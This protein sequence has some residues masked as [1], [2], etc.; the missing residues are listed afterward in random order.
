MNRRLVAALIVP[1]LLGLIALQSPLPAAPGLTLRAQASSVPQIISWGGAGDNA[2]DF[3]FKPN[4]VLTVVLNN[5]VPAGS[6]LVV[7]AQ[8]GWDK[9]WGALQP[10]PYTSFTTKQYYSFIATNSKLTNGTGFP[11]TFYATA[12]IWTAA[13][14]PATSSI[15]FYYTGTPQNVQMYLY[16]YAAVY[17]NAAGPGPVTYRNGTFSQT[18]YIPVTTFGK[19][20]TLAYFGFEAQNSVTNGCGTGGI[21]AVKTTGLSSSN[22]Y[23]VTNTSGSAP[24]PFG[25]YDRCDF[26]YIG[27]RGLDTGTLG[28]GGTT[29]TYR[30]SD[31]TTGN[32]WF[33]QFIEV[34]ANLVTSTPWVNPTTNTS[35]PG[36]YSWLPPMVFVLGLSIMV[37]SVIM[38]GLDV[39]RRLK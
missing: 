6:L 14:G 17:S 2:Q 27:I 28:L 39:F 37:G 22:S 10:T 38:A 36:F 24:T 23:I 21:S 26:P 30:F 25:Y 15:P 7:F 19:N 16:V 5:P 35:S 31:Y 3:N 9:N 13:A 32:N 11:P 1:V 33:Y 4:F 8:A 12:G 29:Y 18:Q 34:E 20:S